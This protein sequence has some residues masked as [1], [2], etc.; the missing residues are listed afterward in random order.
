MCSALPK[1]KW[2]WK[3]DKCKYCYTQSKIRKHKHKGSGLC[4]SCYDKIRAK[5]PKRQ[6]QLKQQHKKWYT[7]VKDTKEYKEYTKQIGKHWRKNSNQY[8]AYL[9][10][11]Y[12]RLSF[13][14]FI[15]NQ[16]N[17]TGILN[18]KR[19]IDALKFRCD[20]CDKNCLVQTPINTE[21]ESSVRKLQIFKKVL[22]QICIQNCG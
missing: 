22:K 6:E 17:K 1:H 7:K 20:E 8:K 9:K 5:K 12:L 21:I 11:Q 4:L 16:K 14:R 3:Y 19:S 15:L 10:K 18:L 2:S 13:K